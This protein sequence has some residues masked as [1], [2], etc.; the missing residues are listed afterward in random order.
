[1]TVLKLRP[2]GSGCVS[3]NDL[4]FIEDIVDAQNAPGISFGC[5][6]FSVCGHRARQSHPSVA[7]PNADLACIDKRV[8]IKRDPNGFLD[9]VGAVFLGRADLDPVH[10]ISDTGHPPGHDPGQSLGRQP[11]DRAVQSDDPLLH[12]DVDSAARALRYASRA[13]KRLLSDR[14][15][16]ILSGRHPDGLIVPL[17]QPLSRCAA[18]HVRSSLPRRS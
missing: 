10:D 2:R 6:A 1:L 9:H 4:D 13:P 8:L 14:L 5:V 12:F 11:W 15:L 17:K 7:D 3:G 16:K 18:H